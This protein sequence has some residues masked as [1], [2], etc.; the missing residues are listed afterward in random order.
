MINTKAQALNENVPKF[1]LS[2]VRPIPTLSQYLQ[3]S[4]PTCPAKS[5]E[6]ESTSLAL[7]NGASKSTAETKDSLSESLHLA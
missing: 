4:A 2:L 5:P 6:Q 1:S 7:R 3:S